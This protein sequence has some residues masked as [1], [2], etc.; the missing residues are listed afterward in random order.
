MMISSLFA[1]PVWV[2]HQSGQDNKA[3]GTAQSYFPSFDKKR[4]ALIRARKKL[5][6]T[7]VEQ[8]LSEF[9][10]P[11]HFKVVQDFEDE[12]GRYFLLLEY[13]K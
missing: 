7:G 10:K 4:V 1:L 12:Q 6:E 9:I 2:K 11:E 13:L 8:N 5:Y 3:V